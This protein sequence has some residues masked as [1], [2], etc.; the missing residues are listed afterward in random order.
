M[1]TRESGSIQ[2]SSGEYPGC[3]EPEKGAEIVLVTFD[4]GDAGSWG[5]PSKENIQNCPNIAKE[6]GM[7]LIRCWM[8]SGKESTINAGDARD[9]VLIPGLGEE[10]QPTPVFLPGESHG[11]RSLVGSRPWNLRELDMTEHTHA[12]DIKMTHL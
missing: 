9:T 7:C 11:R 10:W 2:I 3:Q 1:G 5:P 4:G 12:T 6:Q 8:L